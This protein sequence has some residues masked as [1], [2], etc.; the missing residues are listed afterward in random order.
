MKYPVSRGPCLKCG[1]NWIVTLELHEALLTLP[2]AMRA[3]LRTLYEAA[4]VGLQ[5]IMNPDDELLNP[6]VERYRSIADAIS[7]SLEQHDR[8]E[9]QAATI[10][11]WRS[12]LNQ[13]RTKEPNLITDLI[14]NRNTSGG[15]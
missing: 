10:S 7:K 4:A 8:S 14:T 9:V 13:Q 3:E 11:F 6:L 12:M 1:N 15:D 5:T 2:P